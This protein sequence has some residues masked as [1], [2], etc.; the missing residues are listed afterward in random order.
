LR[1][2][3]ALQPTPP[4]PVGAEPAS[5]ARFKLVRAEMTELAERYRDA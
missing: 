5:E 4:L 3:V 2:S 1:S